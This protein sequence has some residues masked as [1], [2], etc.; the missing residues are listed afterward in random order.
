MRGVTEYGTRILDNF[1]IVPLTKEGLRDLLE[2]LEDCYDRRQERNEAP[3]TRMK[4]LADKRK[5]FDCRRF[6]RILRPEGL[7]IK[8]N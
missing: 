7:L 5:R 8:I 6:H 4:E 2:I 1:G 3:R